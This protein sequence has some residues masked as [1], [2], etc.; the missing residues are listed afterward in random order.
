MKKIVTHLLGLSFFM[1]VLSAQ[2]ILFTENFEANQTAFTINSGDVGGTNFGENQWIINNAYT[3]GNLV[4]TCAGIPLP[5]NITIPTTPAQPVGIPTA[6]GRYLHIVSLDGLSFSNNIVNA[7]YK[8]ADATCLLAESYFARMNTDVNTVGQTN[9]RLRFWYLNQACSDAYGQVYY[10]TNGGNT[11]TLISGYNNLFNVGN[12]TQATVQLPVFDNQASLR[13]GFRFVNAVTS[14]SACTSPS[15]SIDNVVVLA[16][17]PPILIPAI[18]MTA[19]ALTYYCQNQSDVVT[20]TITDGPMSAGNQ[21]TLELSDP[22]GSFASPTVLATQ[23]GTTGGQFN[24]TI[25]IAAPFGNNYQLRVVGSN[26]PTISNSSAPF[27]IYGQANVNLSG[28][29][30]GGTLTLNAAGS[31]G[32]QSYVW[33]P[34]DGTPPTTTPTTQNIFNHTYTSNGLY[35][36]CL[37]VV[38]PCFT[39]QSCYPALICIPGGGGPPINVGFNAQVNGLS[40]SISDNSVSADSIYIDFG[41]GAGQ[42]MVPGS[43]INYTYPAQGTFTICM[44]GYNFCDVSADTLCQN[45]V[46]CLN[47]GGSLNVAFL[48]TLFGNTLLVNDVSLGADSLVID[49]GDGTVQSFNPGASLSHTYLTPGTYTYCV[50]GFNFCDNAT[51]TICASVTV[52]ATANEYWAEIPVKVYPNPAGPTFS[53]E[54]QNATLSELKLFTMA[55]QYVKSFDPSASQHGINEIPAGIYLLQATVNQQVQHHRLVI[56]H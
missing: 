52:V 19:P 34:G 28:N 10:S 23:A 21:Y 32:G 31:T 51:N 11:W 49:F 13:F 29:L 41:N 55:G 54:I 24:F 12:W 2:T 53:V 25:P 7:N 14:N 35:N 8:A 39:A 47:P 56:Q 44:Y 45:V 46:I 16:D 26:P 48:D 43:Q 4:P 22:N 40:V 5:I 18:N 38:N 9:T 15:F 33:N 27:S 3:G 50:T 6:N 17:G 37:T 42:T 30:V 1:S 20:Y 36:A